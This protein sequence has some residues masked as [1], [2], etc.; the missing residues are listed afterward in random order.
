MQ[1]LP[2]VQVLKK[3]NLAIKRTLTESC[4]AIALIRDESTTLSKA[5]NSPAERLL[6]NGAFE[7]GVSS[8]RSLVP[9]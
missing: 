2:Y 9:H 7:R 3:N 5:V 8:V 6:T 1:A 4:K